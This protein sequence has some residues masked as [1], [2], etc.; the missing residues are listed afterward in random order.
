MVSNVA[1]DVVARKAWWD[2]NY[3]SVKDSNVTPALRISGV[4]Y[5]PT[6][7]AKLPKS[8]WLNNSEVA[9]LAGLLEFNAD[10]MLAGSLLTILVS[11]AQKLMYES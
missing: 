8:D 7:S 10:D 1:R 4:P 2:N 5:D 9:K 11:L 6:L 3:P